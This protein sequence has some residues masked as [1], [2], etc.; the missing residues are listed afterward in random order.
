[1]AWQ[2]WPALSPTDRLL[3]PN[4][5]PAE[6]LDYLTSLGFELPDFGVKPD[7][8]RTFTAFGWNP[9]AAELN[10]NYSHPSPHPKLEIVARV[11]SREFTLLL[12]QELFPENRVEPESVFC[13]TVDELTRWL[14]TASAKRWVAKGNHGHAGI[15]QHRFSLPDEKQLAS[16]VLTRILETQ[17]GLVLEPEH[18]INVEFGCLFYL[19]GNGTLSG[20]KSHRLLSYSGGGFAGSL[21]TPNDAEFSKWESKIGTAARQIGSK[22]HQEGYF[23]P[24]GIDMYAWQ[25]R[26]ELLFRSL[27]DLNARCSM[28]YPVHGL[29]QRFPNRSILV[30]Q[31]PATIALPRTPAELKEKLG[32]HHFDPQT[33]TG[34]FLTTPLMPGSRRHAWAFIG[35]TETDLQIMRDH[36]YRIFA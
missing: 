7:L 6:Y 18:R 34:A 30:S 33:R 8:K 12:E 32:E 29:A 13:R 4:P 15:G 26:D 27:V 35:K 17:G 24:V 2:L 16:P 19:Q 36:V 23:G 5:P 11:N 1:M 10:Q 22:L 14:E 3:V 28:A 31:V 20:L 25:D 9:E 21:L